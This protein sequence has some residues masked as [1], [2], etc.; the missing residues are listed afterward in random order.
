MIPRFDRLVI[1]DRALGDPLTKRITER[2]E[3]PETVVTDDPGGFRERGDFVLKYHEG[4]FV[5]DF[6]V[7]PGAPPCGEK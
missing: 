2:L 3:V 7:T 4:R 6:P 1:E 5:K